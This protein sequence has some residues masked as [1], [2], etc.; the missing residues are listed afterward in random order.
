MEAVALLRKPE[1]LGRGGL[2]AAGGP[3][4]VDVRIGARC[5][6]LLPDREADIGTLGT[7]EEIALAWQ[8][9]ASGG[10]Y[11]VEKIPRPSQ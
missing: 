3:N 8:A 6:V 11:A 4:I 2:Q 7:D 9:N 5:I 1:A 10:A